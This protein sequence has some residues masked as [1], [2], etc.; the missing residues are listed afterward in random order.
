MV[1]MDQFTRRII[2][3][4]VHKGDIDGVSVCCMFNKIIS[5][6]KLPKYIST[7]N[8]PLFKFG[9][10]QANLRILEIEEIKSVP[11]TPISH[12]F[13]E[14]L[15]RTIREDLLNN[16]LIWNACDL[17]KKLDT[18]Q[19]YFNHYRSHSAINTMTPANKSTGNKKVTSINNYKW[20]KHLHGLIQLPI[21]S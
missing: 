11:Y 9:K 16:L 13:V 3:F 4:A 20:K 17:Q 18:Y 21:A 7:D 10:W 12:P 14:R 5:N 15:I 19:D 2:G 8:D 1:I 6:Q